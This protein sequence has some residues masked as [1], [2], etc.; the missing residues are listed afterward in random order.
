MLLNANIM[1]PVGEQTFFASY[2]EFD[3]EQNRRIVM[4]YDNRPFVARQ[5]VAGLLGLLLYA[6]APWIIL[7]FVEDE[8]YP[9]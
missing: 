3:T 2:S 6:G 7:W 5:I 1:R 4:S 9:S 8:P